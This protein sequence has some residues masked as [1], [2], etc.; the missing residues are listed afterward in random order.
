MNTDDIDFD[1]AMQFAKTKYPTWD[2]PKPIEDDPTERLL[3]YCREDMKDSNESYRDLVKRT[4][5]LLTFI[6]VFSVAIAQQLSVGG[7]GIHRMMFIVSL[8][9]ACLAVA[10]AMW[11]RLAVARPCLP[12]YRQQ[13]ATLFSSENAHDQKIWLGRQYYLAHALWK[14]ELEKLN[15]AMKTSF[16]AIVIAFACAVVALALR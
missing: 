8:G 2:A 13:E 6:G 10:S 3:E 16:F 12:D 1:A 11:A 7:A 5:Y 9:I 14:G 15:R 4:D